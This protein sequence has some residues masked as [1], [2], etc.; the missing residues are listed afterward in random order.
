MGVAKLMQS[1]ERRGGKRLDHWGLML[2]GSYKCI[3]DSVHVLVHL[4]SISTF[5][6]APSTESVS[7]RVIC[8]LP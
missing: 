3:L 6:P 2:I 1:R 8:H 7:P 4:S 5:E